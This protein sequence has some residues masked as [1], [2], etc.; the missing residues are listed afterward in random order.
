MHFLK[1]PQKK[2]RKIWNWRRQF[3]RQR[4][5][6]SW[7]ITG[8]RQRST[9]CEYINLYE[10]IKIWD[11]CGKKLW[12]DPARNRGVDICKKIWW[13]SPL[14]DWKRDAYTKNKTKSPVVISKWDIIAKKV[15]IYPEEINCRD[16]YV[17]KNFICP[18]RREVRD[19][20]IY[21]FPIY[22]IVKKYK[23]LL[24]MRMKLCFNNVILMHRKERFL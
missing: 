11:I 19:I 2:K 15:A 9:A 24:Y 22:P 13:K 8:F 4:P 12:K 7:R 20:W 1:L 14:R 3:Y 17:K 23:N 6:N 10:K 5:T 21:F 16:I 18:N